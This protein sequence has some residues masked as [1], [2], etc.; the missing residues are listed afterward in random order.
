[1]WEMEVATVFEVVVVG[2]RRFFLS[3][4]GGWARVEVR[5]G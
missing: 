2:V 3:P 4:A 1:M 5:L